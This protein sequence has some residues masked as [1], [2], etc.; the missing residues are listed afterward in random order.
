MARWLIQLSGERIDLE[1]FLRG[2]PDG[3]IFVI[4]EDQDVFIVGPALEVLTEASLVLEE[5][6]RTVDQFSGVMSLIYQDFRKPKV[7]HVYRETDDGRRNAFIFHAGII[8]PRG[9]F[10]IPTIGPSSNPCGPTKEQQMLSLA[11]SSRYLE[12]AITLWADPV[13]PWPRLYRILEEIERHIGKNVDTAGL[14]SAKERERFRR[15]ANTAE[16]SGADSRHALSKYTPPPDP[17]SHEEA[18]SFVGR[19]FSDMLR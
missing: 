9:Q 19:I 17:M 8:A 15:T 14:C 10:G 16:V 3:D 12:V 1:K 6:V 5:A 13:R 7:S 2:F 11:L 4:E 18:T